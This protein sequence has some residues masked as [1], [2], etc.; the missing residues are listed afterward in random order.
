MKRTI[1]FFAAIAFSAVG[2]AYADYSV[3]EEGT[4]PVS[5]PKE[6]APL[7]KQARSLRGSLADITL[8]EISFN[9]R[10]DFESAWPN[11]L[12]VKTKGAP[13]FLV[14]GPDTWLGKLDAGVRIHC[15]PGQRGEPVTPGTPIPGTTDARTRWLYTNYI[16]LIVDGEVVDL[17]RISLPADTP[18]IDTRFND[19]LTF[20]GAEV[21]GLQAG[22]GY[23][24]GE[25]RA[26][27]Q[28]ETVR[29]VVRVR[30]IGKAEVNFQYLRQFFIETPP[31]VTDDKGKPVRLEGFP[32][33]FGT[34]IPVKA[35][36]APGKET[37]LYEL[38]LRPRPVSEA[39]VFPSQKEGAEA[40]V[41]RLWAS[42]KVYI[43]YPRV[44]G[45]SSSGRNELD[46]NLSKLATGKLELEINPATDAS[47]G[48]K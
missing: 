31:A 33:A 44:I 3:R 7:R 22:L 34:H 45:T 2:S 9:K 43:Q 17:N 26:Y 12:K 37:E 28:G 16:E 35:N 46:P 15:P 29:L 6:L 42:G 38:R 25:D 24:R 5:W 36:L 27:S 21:D 14:R 4:W 47:T 48:K 19:G 20:W 18:I 23:H 8:Y 40:S 32:T 39:G 1:A 11:I 13:V 30:N 10:E 41:M